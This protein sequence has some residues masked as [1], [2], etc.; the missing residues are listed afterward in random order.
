MLINKITDATFVGSIVESDK[1]YKGSKYVLYKKKL[2]VKYDEKIEANKLHKKCLAI[3]YFFCVNDKIVKIGQTSGKGGIKDCLNFYCGAGQDD[4]GPNR[5]TINALIREQLK[6]NNKID[7]YIK[8]IEPCKVK[9]QGINR[10]HSVFTPVSA[11]CLE[12][13]HLKDYIELEGRYPEWNYQELG[14]SIPPHI[15]EKYTFYLKKRQEGR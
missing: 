9:I 15:F 3:V 2:K 13:V 14:E 8:Y 10:S 5:F 12:E 1:I 11:K 4:P 6:I 7:L